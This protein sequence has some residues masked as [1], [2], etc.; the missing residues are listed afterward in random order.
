MIMRS[1]ILLSCPFLCASLLQG[2]ETAGGTADLGP[3]ISVSSQQSNAAILDVLNGVPDR[4]EPATHEGTGEAVDQ[5][6]K[7]AQANANL[8]NTKA[9][10]LSGASGSGKRAQASAWKNDQA[11]KAG[12]LKKLGSAL[13]VIDIVST[14]AKAAGHLVEGDAVGAGQVVV[15]DLVKKGTAAVGAILGT[16]IGGPLGGVVGAGAGEELHGATTDKWIADKADSIRD[17]QAQE[18]MLGFAQAGRYTGQLHWTYNPPAQEGAMQPP[19]SIQYDGPITAD[20]DKDGNLK[21][22]Y[23]LKGGMPGLGVSGATAGIGM[24]LQMSAAGDLTGTAKDGSFNA[25]GISKGTTKF[26][27]DYGG[28]QGAPEN[29]SQS[30]SGSGPVKATGTYTR[31]TMTG[32]LTSP[33]GGGQP[34]SFTLTKTR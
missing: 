2:Q 11:K 29:Q 9:K 10:G 1:L 23:D 3:V 22:H 5:A 34:I 18:A 7:A 26:N 15:S 31:E 13:G 33:G 28:A 6:Q 8:S 19:M 21:I 27:V 32:T 14:G 20:L 30:N 12:W 16:A 24:S 25:E 17:Q 4:V